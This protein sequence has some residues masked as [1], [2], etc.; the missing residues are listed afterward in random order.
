MEPTQEPRDLLLDGA[1]GP[2]R[3]LPPGG[4]KVE[5]LTQQTKSLAQDITSWIDLKVKLTR[6][7]IAETVEEKKKE[8]G[9]LAAVGVFAA[10]AGIFALVTAGL[11]FSA[12]FIAIGLSRPLS[13]FLGYLLLTLILGAI[14]GILYKLK[15][16]LTEP[17]TKK[18]EVDEKR[19][20]PRL[21][22]TS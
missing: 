2:E 19:L 16:R 15:P 1:R 20:S 18:V 22:E 21:P 11:G 17:A 13:Y 3:Q 4:G 7:E 14:A 8:V 9:V 10:L 6:L 12:I 5:R